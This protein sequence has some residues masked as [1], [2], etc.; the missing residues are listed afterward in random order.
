MKLLLLVF[1]FNLVIAKEERCGSGYNSRVGNIPGPLCE[2][3][4]TKAKEER[5]GP[6]YTSRVGHIPGP[7]CEEEETKAKEEVSLD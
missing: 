4:E 5:C 3:E 7:L 1:L 6:G 2:A